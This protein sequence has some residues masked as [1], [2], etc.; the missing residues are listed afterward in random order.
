MRRGRVGSSLLVGAILIAAMFGIT[1]YPAAQT[2]SGAATATAR[3]EMLATLLT[4]PSPT[5]IQY[6]MTIPT[7]RLMTV[8]MDGVGIGAIGVNDEG[9]LVLGDGRNTVFILNPDLTTA[10]RFPAVQPYALGVHRSGGI[11]VGQRNRA[12]L[13][14]YDK[15]GNFQRVF[16]EQDRA[17]LQTFTVAADGTLFVAWEQRYAPQA[18][19]LTRLD[20]AGNTLYNRPFASTEQMRVGVIHNIAPTGDLK[21]LSIPFSGFGVT[22][23]SAYAYLGEYTSD[24]DALVTMPPLMFDSSLYAPSVAARLADDSLVVLTDNAFGWWSAERLPRVV[25]GANA[26][27]FGISQRPSE[28]QKIAAA[29]RPDGYSLYYAEITN[30]NNLLVGIILCEDAARLSPPPPTPTGTLETF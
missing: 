29:L 24:G 18:T 28:V 17:R 21:R 5:P 11:L 1:S 13:T 26:Y 7:T 20:E 2:D 22:L 25:M 10:L 12:V 30:E 9:Q 19:Y 4:V 3:R 6:T 8:Q 23:S 15:D 14:L 27:R 16:W